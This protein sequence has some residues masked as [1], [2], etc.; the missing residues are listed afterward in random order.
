M[1][2]EKK[3]ACSNETARLL[4]EEETF[5]KE[6]RAEDGFWWRYWPSIPPIYVRILEILTGLVIFLFHLVVYACPQEKFSQVRTPAI[7]KFVSLWFFVFLCLSSSSLYALSSLV[8]VIVHLIYVWYD[9]MISCLETYSLIM[10][11]LPSWLFPRWFDIIIFPYISV[12]VP[13]GA[14]LFGSILHKI[15]IFSD[16]DL[17]FPCIS[18]ASPSPLSMLVPPPNLLFC[19]AQASA[20]KAVGYPKLKD[21]FG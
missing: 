7:I 4:G 14:R 19:V 17:F 3:T 6:G 18:L 21:F 11:M 20:S 2:T 9:N 1:M 12:T 8:L 10:L 13:G 16:S 15:D 5:E